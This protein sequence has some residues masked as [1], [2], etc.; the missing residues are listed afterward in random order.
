MSKNLVIGIISVVVLVGGAF[1]VLKKPAPVSVTQTQQQPTTSATPAPTQVQQKPSS[2]ER[3][4]GIVIKKP[5]GGT[6]QKPAAAPQVLSAQM[7]ASLSS[8]GAALKPTTVFPPTTPTL[9]AVLTLKNAVQRTQLSYI[10]YYEGKYVDSKVSHPS[11]DGA[12][13]FHFDWALKAGKTRKVGNYSLV[14]YIDGKKAQTINY[15][16]K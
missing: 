2:T 1:L 4:R 10:R 15:S 7:S 13:Y 11:K 3:A 6:A 12:Q 5:A 14:F 8:S 16:I 9:Y